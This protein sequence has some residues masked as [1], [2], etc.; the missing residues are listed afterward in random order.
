ME[1]L[2]GALGEPFPGEDLRASHV[3]CALLA[4]C[5]AVDAERRE[6][7]AVN[8]IDPGVRA[9]EEDAALSGH[10]KNL[11]HVGEVAGGIDDLARYPG[12]GQFVGESGFCAGQLRRALGASDDVDEAEVCDAVFLRGAEDGEIGPVVNVPGNGL[13]AGDPQGGYDVVDSFC[14]IGD[15]CGIRDL[16]DGPLVDEAIQ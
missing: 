6:I 5:Q 8:G 1:G 10:L 12:G 11:G 2:K 15:E 16:P 14:D 9:E 3:P 4:V 7:G 13:L